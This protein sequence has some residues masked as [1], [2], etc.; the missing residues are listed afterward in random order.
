M[1]SFQLYI[2]KEL[3]NCI[4]KAEKK[5]VVLLALTQKRESARVVEISRTPTPTKLWQSMVRITGK[6]QPHDPPTSKFK[7]S[8]SS[9]KEGKL[10][11][12]FF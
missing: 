7:S 6:L 2:Q 8:G 1:S 5:D 10:K 3:A 4:Q 11:S 12:N 9:K